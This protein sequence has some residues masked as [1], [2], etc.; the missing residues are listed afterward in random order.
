MHLDQAVLLSKLE[1]GDLGLEGIALHSARERN[2]R[3]QAGPAQRAFTSI[4][5]GRGKF[6][7]RAGQGCM[8]PAVKAVGGFDH[9]RGLVAHQGLQGGTRVLV[10]DQVHIR[11][12]GGDAG[13]PGEGPVTDVRAHA[14]AQR[15]SAGLV[16]RE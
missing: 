7:G 12:A 8:A 3:A 13:K 15:A 2:V 6:E 16:A 1:P 10:Q 5:A 9:Q 4:A 11:L 14:Q